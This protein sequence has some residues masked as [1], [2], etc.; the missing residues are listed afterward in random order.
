MG[1]SKRCL[2]NNTQGYNCYIYIDL[3]SDIT[4]FKNSFYS[5]PSKK[6]FILFFDEK[7]FHVIIINSFFILTCIQQWIVVFNCECI[8]FVTQVEKEN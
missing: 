3:N 2:C 4:W 6:K 7:K 1:I 5:F 8:S